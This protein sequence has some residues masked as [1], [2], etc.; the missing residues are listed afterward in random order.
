MQID[1]DAV[2]DFL[3]SHGRE[4]EVPQAGQEL[5][6]EVDPIRDAGLLSRL[7]IDVHELLAALPESVR[8]QMPTELEERL[9]TFGV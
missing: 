7:G 9:G 6:D 1:K 3:R 8:N 2:L 4:A 5:P